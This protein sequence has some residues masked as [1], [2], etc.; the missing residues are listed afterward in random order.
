MARVKICGITRYED[1]KHA[2]VAGADALGFNFYSGSKRYIE[3]E[4]AK[5]IIEQIAIPW[6][7]VGVFVNAERKFVEQ[8]IKTTGINALQFHGR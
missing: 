6:L 7:S 4:K 2:L 5:I 8:C 1:A 3:P